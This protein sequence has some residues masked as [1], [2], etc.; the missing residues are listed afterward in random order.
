MPDPIDP[1]LAV[2]LAAAAG[3]DPSDLKAQ[4]RRQE[5][6]DDD[7]DRLHARIAELETQVASRLDKP[8]PVVADAEAQDAAEVQSVTP[9][10]AHELLAERLHAAQSRWTTLGGTGG[11][12][13]QAA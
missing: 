6:G 11:P 4:I 1:T 8:T 2:A 10:Q 7:P 3:L 12:D 9:R 13:G 5:A